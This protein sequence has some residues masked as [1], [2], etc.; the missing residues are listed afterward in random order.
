MKTRV[1]IGYVV[2]LTWGILGAR[3]AAA[4]EPFGKAGQFVVSGDRL[5]GV[6]VSSDKLEEATSSTRYTTVSLLSSRFGGWTSVF[7]FPR[8]GLD[9]LVIDGLSVGLSLGYAHVSYE[10]DGGSDTSNDDSALSSFLVAPR[11]GYAFMFNDLI[12]LWP[13]AGV[14][15]VRTKSRYGSGSNESTSSRT[16]GTLEVPLVFRP[17]S[18]AVFSIGPTVDLG[19]SGTNE[20]EG[21]GETSSKA[22]DFGL[23]AGM[24]LYF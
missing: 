2:A 19:F 17:V 6:T 8:I 20:T 22:T 5:F 15:Y 23:Q 3:G 1:K 9:Y 18:H 13:R 7:S 16:A 11:A 14:T 24:S 10:Q 12:G 4:D 21:G